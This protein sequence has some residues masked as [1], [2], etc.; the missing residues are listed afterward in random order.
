MDV[1]SL[2]ISHK[3]EFLHESLALCFSAVRNATYILDFL[4]YIFLIISS[5]HF[6]SLNIILDF[7][8]SFE[9]FFFRSRFG[10]TFFLMNYVN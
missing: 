8:L 2:N 6:T 9:E 1:R 4:L 10:S 7:S 3:G 5:F